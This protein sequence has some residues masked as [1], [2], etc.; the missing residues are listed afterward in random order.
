MRRVGVT[1]R[2]AAGRLPGL[3]EGAGG[4][5]N[6][7]PFFVVVFSRTEAGELRA[8]AA[9]KALSEQH[10]AS[11]A[12]H[13]AGERRGAVVFSQTGEALTGEAGEVE[14]LARIGEVPDDGAL[15]RRFGNN[16]ASGHPGLT[17]APA[18]PFARSLRSAPSLKRLL[19]RMMPFAAA[20]ERAPRQG[21]RYSLALARLAAVALAVSGSGMLVISARAAQREARLV[22]MAR[23]VCDHT[24]TTNQ[25]LHRLVR[26]EYKAGASKK[27]AL[28]KVVA[29]CMAKSEQPR[30]F[31]AHKPG[32]GPA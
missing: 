12:S 9:M 32:T 22:E 19:S 13:L 7:P 5:G 3:G 15:L 26:S 31:G 17:S 11:L 16:R 24:G 25:E 29:H 14:I 2:R 4:M 28:Y 8:E 1:H 30:E 10:A 20:R 21:P 27:E 18:H 23:P 6:I